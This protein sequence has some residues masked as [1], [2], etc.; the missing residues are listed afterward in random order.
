MGLTPIRTGTIRL[1]DQPIH[2]LPSYRIAQHGLALVPEGRQV[3]AITVRENLLATAANRR[4]RATPWTLERIYDIFPLLATRQRHMGNQLSGGEQQMVA[5]GRAPATNPRLLIL[6][7]ATEGLAPSAPEIWRLLGQLRRLASYPGD[8]Q[9]RHCAHAPWRIV[10]TSSTRGGVS[11]RGCH[12]L[13]G[14]QRY[15]P[16][17][18]GRMTS[19]DRANQKA[20]SR[21]HHRVLLSGLASNR[22]E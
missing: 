17:L 7:E 4:R 16:A 6:D 9:T 2:A 20:H 11:G 5:I 19:V 3:F 8:R 22:K 18:F 14:R 21:A 12:R 10:T 1:D 13:T 15:T